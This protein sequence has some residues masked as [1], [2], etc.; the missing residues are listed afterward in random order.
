[1]VSLKNEIAGCQLL[2]DLVAGMLEK[3]ST[4]VED[5]EKLLKAFG[6]RGQNN[7]GELT[8]SYRITEKVLL[9]N[10]HT[11]LLSKLQQ[12]NKRLKQRNKKKK[13]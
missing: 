13:K 3:F 8:V 4:K 9:Q 2:V 6:A 12:L 10:A 11:A 5:D 7:G 1:M